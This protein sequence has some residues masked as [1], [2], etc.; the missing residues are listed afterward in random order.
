MG[1][2]KRIKKFFFNKEQDSQPKER[3]GEVF[4]LLVILLNIAYIL[5][6]IGYNIERESERKGN[7]IRRF[8][9]SWF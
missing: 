6:N 1:M 2:F 7:E 8:F 9:S 5:L 4:F 3:T